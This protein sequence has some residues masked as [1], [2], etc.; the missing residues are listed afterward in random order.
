MDDRL[1]LRIGQ[2]SLRSCHVSGLMNVLFGRGDRRWMA[3]GLE[4][5]KE[6]V[7]AVEEVSGCL[8]RAKYENWSIYELAATLA[9]PG[10]L[11]IRGINSWF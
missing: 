5:M 6:A 4:N 3:G 1:D 7:E 10:L 9:G 2:F 8:R 11:G